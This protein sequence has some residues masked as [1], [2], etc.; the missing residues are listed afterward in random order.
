MQALAQLQCPAWR[1]ARAEVAASAATQFPST[2]CHLNH[3]RLHVLLLPLVHVLLL[4]C[5]S[6]C[7]QLTWE[8]A[9]AEDAMLL[10]DKLLIEHAQ[11]RTQ[12]VPG[13]ARN[14]AT[15]DTAQA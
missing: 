8:A 13:E 9:I 12:E 4:L 10:P 3:S 5:P 7:Q 11:Q 14:A 1:L 2:C 6:F 15:S